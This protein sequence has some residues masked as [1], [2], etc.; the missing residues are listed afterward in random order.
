M[1]K[2]WQSH[3]EQE[4]MMVKR[5]VFNDETFLATNINGTFHKKRHCKQTQSCNK[6]QFICSFAE[7]VLSEHLFC[8]L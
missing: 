5:R 1:F 8:R 4:G 6:I 2:S 3:Q 7:N